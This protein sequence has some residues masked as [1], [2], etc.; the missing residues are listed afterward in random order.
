[1]SHY[2]AGEDLHQQKHG[3]DDKIFADAALARRQ[4]AKVREQRIECSAIGFAE[5]ALVDKEYRAQCK[6]EK[7]E[8]DPGPDE[9]CGR[10]GVADQR[11]I[12]PVLRPRHVGA[13]PSGNRGQRGVD[14]KIG[15][16]PRRLRVEAVGAGPAAGEIIVEQRLRQLI[17]ESEDRRPERRRNRGGGRGKV[18]LAQFGR[19]A[20]RRL[21]GGG[22]AWI[23]EV[24]AGQLGQPYKIG[25]GIIFAEIRPHAVKRAVI[26]QIGTLKPGLAGDDVGG[27]HQHAA[28][29]SDD[30]RRDRRRLAIGQIGRPAQD[31]KA[32]NCNHKQHPFENIADRILARHRLSPLAPAPKH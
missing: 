27:R 22:A 25:G 29:R 16:L 12:G 8:A 15:G 17:L 11:F 18:N 14:Q 2:R 23:G 28:I 3:N 7:A 21:G 30:A 9:G 32:G 26:H 13:G 10:R 31:R 5:K 4:W 6:K 24:G 1:M 19:G 20:R